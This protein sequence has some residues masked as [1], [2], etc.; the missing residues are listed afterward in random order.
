MAIDRNTKYVY[1]HT[2]TAY[3]AQTGE[4][5]RYVLK[6]GGTSVFNNFSNLDGCYTFRYSSVYQPGVYGCEGIR[7]DY[8]WDSKDKIIKAHNY[9]S[10]GIILTSS[11]AEQRYFDANSRV[12]YNSA[13]QKN[14]LTG[15][16]TNL[17]V[18]QNVAPQ[19]NIITGGFD[20]SKY[21][22]VP[23]VTARK[24]GTTLTI[25]ASDWK[26]YVEQYAADY[27]HIISMNGHVYYKS[28][29]SGTSVG[30]S[31]G[32]GL[33]GSRRFYGN[34][35]WIMPSSARTNHYTDTLQTENLAAIGLHIYEAPS[36]DEV[37]YLL[38]VN[39][40]Y[41]LNSLRLITFGC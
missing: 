10:L 5:I 4:T 15:Q 12:F 38:T 31:T 22:F 27:P 25:T 2:S 23:S 8:P 20:L 18:N 13:T 17:N 7:Q 24:P 1:D 6:N 41:Y 11:S 34:L 37:Y 3:G 40:A 28:D 26:T 9:G 33:C 39:P 29:L 19:V 14:I 32:I 30:V 36:I 21:F 16:I 35:N